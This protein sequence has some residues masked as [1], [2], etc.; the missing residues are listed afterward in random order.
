[1]SAIVGTSQYIEFFDNPHGVIQGAIGSALAA[2]S[3]V[4]SLMAGPLSDKIGR[5]DSIFIACFWWLA[6]TAVQVSCRNY[7]QL[8]AGRVLNGVCV[9]ITSSQVPVYLAEI[10][11]KDKRGSIIVIQQLA[12]E[13]GIFI[14]F[15]VGYGCSFIGGNA[16]FRTAWGIQFVPAVIL[17]IGLPFLPRSPRWLAKVGRDVEAI[18]TLADIQAKGNVDDPLVIAEWEEISTVL[19]AERSSP[20]SW[21]KFVYNGMWKRTL[22]GM[23]VQMWQQNSGANVMT[24]YVV[25]VFQMAGLTGNVNLISSGIQYALFII[26]TTVVFFFID[27][28]GRRPLLI[29]GAIGMGICQLVVGGVMGSYG[30][31]V[32]DGV[33]TNGVHNKNVLIQVT[34]APAHTIIA[35]CYLLIIIYALTLAPGA[36]VYA[37]EVWSLETRATGM[38]LAAVANWLFNF[39]LGLYV[40]PAFITI[41]W[42]IFIVFGIL[43]F[44]A[45]VQAYFTYPETCGKTI[46]EIE[47]LFSKGGPKPWNTKPGDSRLESEIEA[48]VARKVEG[49]DVLPQALHRSDPEKGSENHQV[50]R[51][52]PAALQE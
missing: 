41:K 6:G 8:I 26:F 52:E 15:F 32:P 34:G 7:G 24:Y 31:I 49:Q 2:G 27:K 11:K 25:Y 28:T 12:I 14:M 5:R 20:K 21:R 16:S 40:P 48:V 1:M 13:W 50:E 42:K 44:A 47:L 51:S 19:A 37:A 18:K 45:A 3:V 43:C 38:S 22:A 9:G 29:Y 39:A 46:E 35:F 33:I 36:W 17:M 23:S 4:G 30:V 10:A